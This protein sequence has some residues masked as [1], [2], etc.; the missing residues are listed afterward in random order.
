MG[1]T[2]Q[3]MYR[4]FK[5]NKVITLWDLFKTFLNQAIDTHIPS[6]QIRN[7]T[8]LPWMNVQLKRLVR[9]KTRLHRQAEKSRNW[10]VFDN[11]QKTCRDEF[12]KA[13]WDYVNKTISES[14]GNKNSKPLWSY[15]K[16]KKN[17]NLGVSPL[18]ENGKIFSESKDRAEILLR[19]FSS[20]FTKTVSLFMPPVALFID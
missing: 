17:D 14:L 4:N 6:K 1:G 18:K 15:I 2:K 20:V 16:S 11:F 19:Q 3:G 8:N 9:K 7:N 10:T 5:T 12:R 13:E